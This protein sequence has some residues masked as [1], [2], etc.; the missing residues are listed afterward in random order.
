MMKHGLIAIALC[1]G[2]AGAAQAREARLVRSPSYHDGKV[3][4]SY[5]GDIWMAREDGS[6]IVRFTV[7]KARD[8]NPRFSPDGKTI[9][10]SSDREGGWT[11]T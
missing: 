7:N 2:L 10:F 8:L 6:A 9:A 4:F 1:L 11:S 5:L 3:V